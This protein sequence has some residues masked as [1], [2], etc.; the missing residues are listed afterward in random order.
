LTIGRPVIDLRLYYAN[1]SATNKLPRA[2]KKRERDEM[3][4]FIYWLL[5]LLNVVATAAAVLHASNM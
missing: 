5:L 1:S 2:N 4:I 3:Y